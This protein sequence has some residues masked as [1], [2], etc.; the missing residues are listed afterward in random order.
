[1]RESSSKAS[2]RNKINNFE[3]T[4]WSH[5]VGR[6]LWQSSMHSEL[7]RSAFA[8]EIARM[9][10]LSLLMNSNNMFRIWISMSGGW[11][12]TGT[13]VIPGRSINVKLRTEK[14]EKILKYQS[15]SGYDVKLIRCCNGHDSQTAAM[16]AYSGVWMRLYL[17]ESL[18]RRV[19]IVC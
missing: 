14:I 1:M 12:P 6:L 17:V 15:S 8:G 19:W 13:F 3:T 4:R 5:L 2:Q 9:R 18:P 10:Q 16:L 7:A 11:S